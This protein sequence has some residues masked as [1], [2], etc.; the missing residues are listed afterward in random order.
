VTIK[1]FLFIPVLLTLVSGCAGVGVLYPH[2][3]YDINNPAI[4]ST[5]GHYFSNN[6]NRA[7]TCDQVRAWWGAPDDSVVAGDNEI[8]VYKSGLVFAG[9]M[10]FVVVPVPLALPVGQKKI[11]VECVQGRVVRAYKL[12]TTI[13]AAYCG[14]INERP[15]F[16]CR[17][18]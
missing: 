3:W 5:P 2:D 9:V 17:V 4:G 8:L 15:E 6:T 16:G 11:S 12:G 7:F 18:D 1:T 10:P 13:S 14:V